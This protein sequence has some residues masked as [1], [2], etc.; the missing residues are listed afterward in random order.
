MSAILPAH[1]RPPPSRSPPGGLGMASRRPSR[2]LVLFLLVLIASL[3]GTGPTV[4]RRPRHPAGGVDRA[5]APAAA[6]AW[7]IS[8]DV[9]VG[10]VVTGGAGASDEWVELYGRGP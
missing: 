2:L 4:G 10:E 9:V 1:R 8:S 7:P 5:V 6:A 3:L